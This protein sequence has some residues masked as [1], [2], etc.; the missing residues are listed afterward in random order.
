MVFIR[1]NLCGVLKFGIHYD[2]GV[3]IPLV[4]VEQCL[5][6]PFPDIWLLKPD[7]KVLKPSRTLV[8]NR[9]TN[10]LDPQYILPSGPSNIP[11]GFHVSYISWQKNCTEGGKGRL[12][13]GNVPYC[14]M[15]QIFVTVAGGTELIELSYSVKI[16]Y[17]MSQKLL[18]LKYLQTRVK[19]A[20]DGV[21]TRQLVITIR[22]YLYVT[23]L[24]GD[25]YIS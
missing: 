6:K 4:R 3:L 20:H 2:N 12:W 24:N 21:C 11:A 5:N 9:L 1:S 13:T 18:G 10:P 14:Q 17:M 19:R 15:V 23:S 16:H 7:G 8:T 25:A 22:Q